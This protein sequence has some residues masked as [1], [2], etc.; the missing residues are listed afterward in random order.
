[1]EIEPKNLRKLKR[2]KQTN[3]NISINNNIPNWKYF[4]LEL[5][6][7]NITRIQLFN[8]F[9]KFIDHNANDSGIQNKTSLSKNYQSILPSRLKTLF[10]EAK[11]TKKWEN[12]LR[13]MTIKYSFPD[14]WRK[15]QIRGQGQGG[16]KSPKHYL[17]P[18]I[19]R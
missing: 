9:I 15:E 13:F 12:Y 16:R 17:L 11:E 14:T 8:N 7:Y 6:H 10:Y 1:M 3:K 4:F 2:E 18:C 19:Q 5:F